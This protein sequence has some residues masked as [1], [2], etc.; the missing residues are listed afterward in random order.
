[1]ARTKGQEALDVQEKQ[2][3]KK[4]VLLNQQ[5]KRIKIDG[6]ILE[7][8]LVFD[9][10]DTRVKPTD[11][12]ATMARAI[13]IGVMALQENRISAFLANTKDELAGELKN[14]Q[15]RLDMKQKFFQQTALKGDDFENIVYMVLQKHI[16]QRGFDDLIEL[17]G[18]Q[19][20]EIPRNKTGDIT[21]IVREPDSSG[22]VISR[23][24]AIECK[25]KKIALGDISSSCDIEVKPGETAWSQMLEASVNRNA[26]TSIIVID[27]ASADA[28]LAKEVD[29]VKY[30]KDIGFV[31]VIDSQAAD[32]RNLTI[33]YNLAR[34]LVL[35]NT[36]EDRKI[37]N[38]EFVNMLIERIVAE[39]KDINS[40]YTSVEKNIENNKK[41]L[42]QIK[43]NSLVIEFTQKYLEA[44][45][46]DG[47]VISKADLWDFFNREDVR[48]KF[49]PISGEIDDLC[50]EKVTLSSQEL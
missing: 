31:C 44:Y 48:N 13:H 41:I 15:V 50:K 1:M 6:F 19:T 47:G 11:Y 22:G 8:D 37:I 34:A 49:L 30:I 7:D 45:I 40:I 46:K 5:D 18:R 35:N 2:A 3:K 32:N 42:K 36:D 43:K 21:S 24:I 26:D 23:S 33:S 25:Y 39:M 29:G 27:A 4:A 16:K 10:F 38:A 20:G 12:D 14:L 17:K 9:Y 28:S